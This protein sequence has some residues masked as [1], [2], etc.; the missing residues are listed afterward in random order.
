MQFSSR[1]S[2]FGVNQAAT[3]RP[4]REK[5]V[6]TVGALRI[7][8]NCAM[9]PRRVAAFESPAART[10]S[11]AENE[12][13][14][15]KQPQPIAVPLSVSLL[16]CRHRSNRGFVQLGQWPAGNTILSSLRPQCSSVAKQFGFVKRSGPLVTTCSAA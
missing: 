13:L 7:F 12:A 3:T 8:W 4:S 14:R 9:K 11:P 16:A 15:G 6:G 10:S 1:A 2:A 5:T